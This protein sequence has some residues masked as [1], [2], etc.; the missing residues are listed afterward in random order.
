VRHARFDVH[1][2]DVD[3]VDLPLAYGDLLVAEQDGNPTLQWELQ[4]VLLGEEG[5]TPVSADRAP[6]SVSLL[7]LD[8]RRVQG[9]AF[10]VRSSERMHVFRGLV[11]LA[12]IDP[13]ELV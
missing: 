4:V 7:L 1:R 12:G 5:P 3:G 10:L 9:S 13:A 6:S 8:G 11:P 2:I